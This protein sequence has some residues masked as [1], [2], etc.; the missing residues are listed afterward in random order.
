MFVTGCDYI[1][2]SPGGISGS[3]RSRQDLKA[4]SRKIYMASNKS[5]YGTH[6]GSLSRL[7]HSKNNPLE[8]GSLYPFTC[9]RRAMGRY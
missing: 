7:S 3:L 9:T 4:G 2:K 8:C 5:G 6:C 1:R